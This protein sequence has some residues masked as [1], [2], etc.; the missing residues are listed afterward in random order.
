MQVKEV[1]I[2]AAW[3]YPVIGKNTKFDT[4]SG[5]DLPPSRAP[6][7]PPVQGNL[8]PFHDILTPSQAPNLPPSEAHTKEIIHIQKKDISKKT[9]L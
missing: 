1:E 4:N 2:K 5:T 8:P 6:I 3:F 7:L 9:N